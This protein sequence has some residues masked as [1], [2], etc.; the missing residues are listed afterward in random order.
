VNDQ[1]S[2]NLS[3]DL[4]Q[5]A[6]AAGIKEKQKARLNRHYKIRKVQV[7]RLDV[8]ALLLPRTIAPDSLFGGP[9]Q[10]LRKLN[11]Q[12]SLE[13]ELRG[14][15]QRS[16]FAGI[17][18]N[19]GK[20]LVANIKGCENPFKPTRLDCGIVVS[21]DSIR[22]GDLEIAEVGPS[23]APAVG[24]NVVEA[25]QLADAFVGAKRPS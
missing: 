10:F 24:V 17:K 9:V 8:L 20:I 4:R 19:K 5:H 3:H 23:V 14:Q 6:P 21:F 16:P 2:S 25:V 11:T 7:Q 22:A 12:D 13:R 1:R 15:Q 18:I